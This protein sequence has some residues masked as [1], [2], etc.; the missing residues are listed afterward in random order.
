MRV[1]AIIILIFPFIMAWAFLH[2]LWIEVKD[3]PFFIKCDMRME[4]K[5]FVL[6]WKAKSFTDPARTGNNH[7]DREAA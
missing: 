6:S 2:R 3:I 7:T 4:W 1:R 5:G